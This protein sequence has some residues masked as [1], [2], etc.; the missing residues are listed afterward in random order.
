MKAAR[1]FTLIELLV[2]I[3][4]IA[5]LS[6][7]LLSALSKA[8]E[9]ASTIACLNNLKQW[10]LA[11]QLYA[12][13]YN[14]FLPRD[15]KGAPLDSDLASATY[16]G[17]YIDL[18]AMI[19]IERYADVPWRMD[20]AIEPGRSVWICPSNKRRARVT[21][22]SHNLFHYSNNLHVNG[23]ATP[24]QHARLGTMPR[25]TVTVWLFDNGGLAAT[26]QQN[27]VHSNLHSA[28][29]NFTFLDGHAA[30][31]KNNDYWDFSNH[32]G[33]T[34]NPNLIWIPK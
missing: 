2:V 10:G 16:H 21:A 9:K 19:S 1:A 17:W 13:D 32:T 28:G 11:T 7:L 5:I 31:F 4:I 30:R 27:N 33:L 20:P 3:A 8:K 15:G 29:A 12:A 18:P 26:A 6:A 25:P 14:D 34:N 24:N 23:T 22:S